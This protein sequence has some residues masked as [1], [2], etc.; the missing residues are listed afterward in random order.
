MQLAMTVPKVLPTLVKSRK[1]IFKKLTFQH[2]WKEL[3]RVETPYNMY[4]ELYHK[5]GTLS[6]PEPYLSCPLLS[7]GCVD[8]WWAKIVVAVAHCCC[9]C[10][11]CCCCG[12][13]W[14]WCW[15][16]GLADS[17]CCCRTVF[18]ERTWKFWLV[19]ATEGNFRSNLGLP[20]AEWVSLLRWLVEWFWLERLK[21][22]NMRRGPF[23]IMI[24]FSF[25][26]QSK[27]FEQ[28]QVS[29]WGKAFFKWSH[30]QTLPPWGFFIKCTVKYND[31]KQFYQLHSKRE[32]VMN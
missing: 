26:V 28:T 24:F 10:E 8:C 17:Y 23:K 3:L 19:A 2:F 25:L 15:W 6:V 32:F 7:S 21:K 16:Y 29:T 9:C 5:L 11:W 27:E 13:C 4:L 14:W 1:D 18:S 30:I 31:Y 12:C 20:G 22:A